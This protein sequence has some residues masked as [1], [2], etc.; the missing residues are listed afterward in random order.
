MRIRNST[1][2]AGSQLQSGVRARMTAMLPAARVVEPMATRAE[3]VLAGLDPEQREV[4]DHA[5]G[6]AVRARRGR[7]RQD[8]RH[9]LPDRLRR[10]TRGLRPA[11]GARRDVHRP[12]GR[13]DAQPGCVTLGVGGVQARTF[14]AAA[15]RQLRCFWPRLSAATC[16]SSS[17]QQGRAGRR[18][19]RPAAARHRPGHRARPRPARSSGPR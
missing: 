18:G 3:A 1:L 14:H 10:A 5:P 15:L 2:W 16:P 6:P 4:G 8:P 19:G 9:H 12:G 17:R 11:A 13:R 7:H